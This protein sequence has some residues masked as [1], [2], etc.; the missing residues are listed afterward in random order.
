MTCFQKTRIRI[1]RRVEVSPMSRSSGG[2]CASEFRGI[3][4]NLGG[5]YLTLNLY[6]TITLE[7]VAQLD[8]NR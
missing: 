5:S 6:D 8:R 1:C 2:S 7:W 4:Q 3:V